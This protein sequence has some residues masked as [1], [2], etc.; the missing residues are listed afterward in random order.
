MVCPEAGGEQGQS[1]GMR[2]CRPFV[3]VRILC[4][5]SNESKPPPNQLKRKEL[6]WCT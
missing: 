5:V 4:V 6:L 2:G 1:Q 3:F